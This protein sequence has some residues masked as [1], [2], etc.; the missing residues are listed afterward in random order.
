[1]KSVKELHKKAMDLAEF[2]F[3]AK[4]RGDSVKAEGL[5]RQAFEYESQAARLVPDEPSSEPTRSILYSSAATLALDCHE[6]CKAEQLIAEGLAGNPSSEIEQEL[7]DL[8]KQVRKVRSETPQV[9]LNPACGGGTDVSVKQPIPTKVHE[10][11][12]PLKVEDSRNGDEEVPSL[13]SA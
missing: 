6:L 8:Y 9:A 5:L 12:Q 10:P 3:V 7:R 4:L 1:M 11:K 13:P 2:A